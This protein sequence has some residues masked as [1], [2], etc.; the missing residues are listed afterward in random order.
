MN[1]KQKM[2]AKQNFT[3]FLKLAGFYF[4]GFDFISEKSYTLK[5]ILNRYILNLFNSACEFAS[6]LS[7]SDVYRDFKSCVPW[8]LESS[9]QI[10]DVCL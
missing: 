1:F 10:I 6:F 4:S 8:Q 2:T 9:L 7:L 5:E 3:M